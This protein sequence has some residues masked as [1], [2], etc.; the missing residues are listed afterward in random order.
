[1]AT[2]AFWRKNSKAKTESEP[3]PVIVE[4]ETAMVQLELDIA[5]NDP[6]LAYLQGAPGVVELDRLNLTSEGLTQLREAGVVLIVPLVSQGELVGMIN[7]G[8]RLSEQEYSSDDRKLLAD[9]AAQAAPAVRVAQLARQQQIEA[10]ERE[11]IEQ[12]LQVARLIQQTLLPQHVPELDD[13]SVAVHWQP[14][15]AVGGDFYDFIQLSDGRMAFIIADV[16]D[17]GVPAAL[18]M[19]TTRTLLRAAAERITSPGEVLE[20]VNELLCPDIPEKM[21]V[22][23]FYAILDLQN[24]CMTYANAGHDVPYCR[25]DD[26]VVEL[27]ATGMPLGLLPGMGYEEKELV[28]GEGDEVLFYSDG[29]VEAHAPS[30]EMFGFPHLKELIAAH[31]G[32]DSLIDYLLA[33]MTIFT[34]AGWEQEDDV[35]LVTL[36]CQLSPNAEDD[37]ETVI[38]ATPLAEFSVPSQPG[39]ERFAMEQ[40]AAAVAEVGLSAAQLERLK[41]AVAETTMNAMEHGNQYRDDAPVAISVLASE[42]AVTVRVVDL[43]GDVPIAQAENPDLS[44][45]LAGLQ[46]PRGWGLFLIKNMVDELNTSSDGVHHTA[47]LVMNLTEGDSNVQP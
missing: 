6:L 39:N 16:T 36:S 17:K 35:T 37:T 43:G 44:A 24:G 31:E 25:T 18:V 20:R 13:W 9:L 2:I 7:L 38:T 4:H 3:P 27:R 21:F 42:E 19:A 28:M 23:C 22:T 8:P 5:P 32:D 14:A 10:A 11:R 46:T 47:E 1:M 26:G 34:G 30:G 12:E 33:D 45:K 40:V 41:T 15:R 29:L